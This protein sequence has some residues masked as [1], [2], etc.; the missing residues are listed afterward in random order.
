MKKSRKKV[1]IKNKEFVNTPFRGLKAF[2]ATSEQ[3]EDQEEKKTAD[4]E[5]PREMD[6]SELFLRWVD[7]VSRVKES[8]G[9]D[10]E[11]RARK[12]VKQGRVEEDERREFLSALS[13]MDVTFRD[14][15]P[16][17]KP[18]RPLPAN[19]MRQL[20]SGVIRIDMELD[21]HGLT[22]DEAVQSL[23]RFITGAYNRGQKAVLVITGKGNN[24]PAEPVLLGAV[25]SWLR[26]SGKK[27]VAEFA[28]APRQMGGSGAFV[29]FLKEMRKPEN[30]R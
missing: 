20:K 13:G 2:T 7:G 19:R 23:N 18:L 5:E 9:E 24:S 17:V 10:D 25:A 1:E 30:I 15:F 14:E 12:S 11:A 26:E 29:V 27:M 16:D 6:E 8:G 4:P 22:R 28:P 3:C 21:L